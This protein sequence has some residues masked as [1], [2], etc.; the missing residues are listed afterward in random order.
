ML[1]FLKNNQD[2]LNQFKHSIKIKNIP[3][4]QSFRLCKENPPGQ[5]G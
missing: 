1:F 4:I 3:K 5:E 2:K